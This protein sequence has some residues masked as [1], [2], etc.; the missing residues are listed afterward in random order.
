MGICPG[1]K[2]KITN[3][4]PNSII[5]EIENKKF[6]LDKSIAKKIKVVKR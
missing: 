6:A 3:K 4:L 2:I 1:E 5:V